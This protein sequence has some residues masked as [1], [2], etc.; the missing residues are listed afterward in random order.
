MLFVSEVAER[1]KIKEAPQD[2]D[3][4]GIDKLN[5]ARSEIP[6]I[7]HVDY[8]ARLQTVHKNTNPKFYQLIHSFF[9]KK[10]VVLC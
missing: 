5:V 6:A 9:G 1:K 7:T 2:K 4:F 8:T 3:M 10:L